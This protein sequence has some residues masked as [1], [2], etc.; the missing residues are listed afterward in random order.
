MTRALPGW[1]DGSH[2]HHSLTRSHL[3][4]PHPVDSPGRLNVRCLSAAITQSPRSSAQIS[5]SLPR[6]PAVGGCS[7]SSVVEGGVQSGS[8][9][10]PR[11]SAGPFAGRFP[12]RLCTSRARAV[13]A[14]THD[15]P[16][17]TSDDTR[18]GEADRPAR[19]P[20]RAT[21]TVTPV[22]DQS[23]KIASATRSAAPRATPGVT[24]EYR[25]SVIAMV[26]WPCRSET[27]LGCTPALSAKVA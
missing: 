9:H 8:A 13:G 10:C 26:E 11:R 19:Q 16:D 23:P 1:P 12:G 17:P 25:S 22:V 24:W 4:R 6:K 20:R 27:T 14:H 15:L 7:G 5:L 3:V 2:D 21:I 18:S